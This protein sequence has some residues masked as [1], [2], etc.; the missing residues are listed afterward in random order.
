MPGERSRRSKRSSSKP[1]KTVTVALCSMSTPGTIQLLYD[2]LIESGY[3]KKVVHIK[4]QSGRAFSTK[5]IQDFDVVI[6]CHSKNWKSSQ[7]FRSKFNELT[8]LPYQYYQQFLRE[9]ERVK[10]KECVAM[11]IHDMDMTLTIAEKDDRRQD[12]VEDYQNLSRYVSDVIVCGDISSVSSYCFDAV[13]EFDDE[14]VRQLQ[15]FLR[16]ASR[17]AA[18]RV[19]TAA[20][21]AAS[22]GSD[23]EDEQGCCMCFRKGSWIS[24]K[25]L[26]SGSGSNGQTSLNS[27]PNGY[28]KGLANGSAVRYDSMGTVEIELK[29]V[30]IQ[31][32]HSL[33][34][35]DSGSNPLLA[36]GTSYGSYGSGK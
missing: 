32:E 13:T 17:H 21:A 14:N 1:V 27:N 33:D 10:G 19:P 30:P 16:R 24:R 7:K 9:A 5:D 25:L 2:K 34:L 11:V 4:V 3:A 28:D 31:L 22:A 35:Y 20:T 6:L 36:S 12:F 29:T 26:H 23:R 18:G 8:E 15:K